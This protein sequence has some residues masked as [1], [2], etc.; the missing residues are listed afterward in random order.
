MERVR[1]W[2]EREDT[3]QYEKNEKSTYPKVNKI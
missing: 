3:F 1:I 2:R